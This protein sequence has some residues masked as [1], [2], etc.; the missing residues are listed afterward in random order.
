MRRTE[1]VIFAL[2]TFGE[3]AQAAALAKGADAVAPPGKDF[4]R[5]TLMHYIKDQLVARGVKNG[6]DRHC[7]FNDAQTRA[8]T[9]INDLLR[10]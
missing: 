5:I 8:K 1:R 4:V 7:Q 6:V 3:T 10:D 2:A 9:A